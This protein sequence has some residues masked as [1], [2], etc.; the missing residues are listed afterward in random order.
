VEYTRHANPRTG[1]VFVRAEWPRP[2]E[3][4]ELP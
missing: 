4:D 2:A 3:P 1:E